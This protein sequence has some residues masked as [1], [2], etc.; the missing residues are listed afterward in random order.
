MTC[1]DC[2][3]SLDA[4]PLRR[5]CPRCGGLRRDATVPGQTAECHVEAP[6]P[7]ITI[8][9]TS[10][11]PWRQKWQDVLNALK[12]IEHAYT[13]QEGLNSEDVRRDIEDFFQVCRELA[14]WLWQNTGVSKAIVMKRIRGSHYLRLADGI[15][16]TAKHHT[17]VTTKQ[18]PNPITAGIAELNVGPDGA[19]AQIDWSKPSGAKGE[20]DALDLA[21]G[22]VRSW[23]RFLREQGLYVLGLLCF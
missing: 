7:N 20:R 4:T 5:P 21:R 13:T 14:D 9:Y 22:C 1:P 2:G 23:Q 15:A 3:E 10:P 18:N 19:R 17:R 8:G 16:Q 6:T 12:P 11:R